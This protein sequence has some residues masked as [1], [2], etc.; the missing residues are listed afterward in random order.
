MSG[1]CSDSEAGSP[2]AGLTPNPS[3]RCPRC[4]AEIVI[5]PLLSTAF[6]GLRL[7]ARCPAGCQ[8]SAGEQAA[9][10]RAADEAVYGQSA[11]PKRRS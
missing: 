7:R 1:R 9:L 5:E 2:S 4:G 10:D 6:C 8:W 11:D 3:G